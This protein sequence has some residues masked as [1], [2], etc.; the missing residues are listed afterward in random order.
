MPDLLPATQAFPKLLIFVGR[1]KKSIRN[2]H[3]AINVSTRCLIR[4]VDWIFW[5]IR[6]DV[7]GP[8]IRIAGN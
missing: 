5:D 8:L 3:V 7:Y 6:G 2:A 1:S 4:G